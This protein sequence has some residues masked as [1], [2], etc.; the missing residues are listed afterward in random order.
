MPGRGKLACTEKIP[1]VDLPQGHLGV[2]PGDEPLE[3]YQDR[4]EPQNMIDAEEEYWEGEEA[5]EPFGAEDSE[6]SGDDDHGRLVCQPPVPVILAYAKH[7]KTPLSNCF[8]EETL[9]V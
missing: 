9:L 2:E 1:H 6:K 8:A 3:E 4:H 7:G 5:D